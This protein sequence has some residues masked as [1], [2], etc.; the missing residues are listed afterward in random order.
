M[1]KYIV[2]F[3]VVLAAW[4]AWFLLLPDSEP[5]VWVPLVFTVLVAVVLI[6]IAVTRRLRA[7]RAARELEKALAAQAAEQARSARPDM[8]ADI[9]QMQQEFQKA[10][11]ALKSSKLAKGGEDAL[12]ALPWHLI[13]GPPGSG[14]STAL[15]NAG[16]QFPYMPTS[17]G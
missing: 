3:I 6:A 4:V 9:L 2:S 13:V 17:G 10:I 14:K 1:L 15:R 11:G 16:L 12:Y 7:R 5:Y 8:Q